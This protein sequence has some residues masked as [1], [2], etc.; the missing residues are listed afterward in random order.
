MYI[1]CFLASEE[2]SVQPESPLDSALI[3][4]SSPTVDT[5]GGTTNLKIQQ[6]RVWCGV[7]QNNCGYCVFMLTI[8]HT[9]TH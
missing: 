7:C 6:V 9:H 4:S 3:P 1:A 2:D 8:M 5:A